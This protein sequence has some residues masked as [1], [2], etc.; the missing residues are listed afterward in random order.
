MKQAI[1][2]AMVTFVLLAA[3]AAEAKKPVKPPPPPPEP[4]DSGTIHYYANST[5]TRIFAMD[6]DGTDKTQ[7]PTDVTGKPLRGE[8]SRAAHGGHHWFLQAREIP[9]ESY[10]DGSARRELFAVR[11]D[12][13][14][15]R[16]VTDDPTVMPG[17]TSKADQDYCT[18][19][20]ATLDGVVDG[21]ISYQAWRWIDGEKTA[22]GIYVA[23]F[24]PDD[25]ATLDPVAP[26]RLPL[27]ITLSPQGNLTAMHAWA[28]SGNAVLFHRPQGGLLIGEKA[29]PDWTI[30][31]L[32]DDMAYF[33]G[34]R[35]SHD[36]SGTWIVFGTNDELVRIHPDGTGRATIVTPPSGGS[37]CFAF[38]SPSCTHLAYYQGVTKIQGKKIT[39]TEDI[40]ICAADGGSPV[41]LSAD[42]SDRLFPVGWTSD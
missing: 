9:G 35:W 1:G 14:V 23:D 31:V 15:V 13:D 26:V 28:P 8:P 10:D 37:V 25:L 24:D 42:T 3:G 34:F 5:W 12:G 4:V 30:R 40:Y 22:P 11:A 29:S 16:Q 18:P 19:R 6:P 38:F 17:L 33:G 21:R 32:V 7:M 20:W 41:N 2:I 39:T 36:A 27:A